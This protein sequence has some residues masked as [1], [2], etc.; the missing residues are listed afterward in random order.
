MS[1]GANVC[2]AAGNNSVI[3]SND[4]GDT[5]TD[6]T[7]PTYTEDN[8]DLFYRH[9]IIM[10]STSEVYL[11]FSGGYYRTNDGGS[12]WKRIGDFVDLHAQN[13]SNMWAAN[14][15]IFYTSNGGF[16]DVKDELSN[17]EIVSDF[18]LSQ[19]YPNPF[20]PSTTIWY[21]IPVSGLVKLKVYD[22]LGN[23]I[24][25]LVN[26]YKSPGKYEIQFHAAALPSGVYFYQLTAGVFNSI[27]KLVVIK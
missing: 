13:S 1:Y 18:N 26:E 11:F 25:T 7:P 16:V 27:K 5:W 19:N 6:V 8:K 12:T 24:T 3:K 10:K 14:D 2:F 23:E 17:V 4:G 15:G 20:N 21:Q 9:K 22:I